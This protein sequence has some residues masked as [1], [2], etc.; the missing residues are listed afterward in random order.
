VLRL[1]HERATDGLTVHD[2]VRETSIS[3]RRIERRFREQF[4]STPL[5]EIRRVR[6]Q[7]A[8]Q[9]LTETDLDMPQ[10]AKAAGFGDAR[11]LSVVF[12]AETGQCPS[13]FRRELQ[14]RP[15]KE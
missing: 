4:G 13:A 5:D 8:K 6:I 11:R 15:M 12:K 1:I 7:R 14:Q 3:R 10:L 9:L 2:L